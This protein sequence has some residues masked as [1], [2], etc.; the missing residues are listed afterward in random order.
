MLSPL[1]FRRLWRTSAAFAALAPGLAL[2]QTAPATAPAATAPPAATDA[3]A[4]DATDTATS[5]ATADTS[6]SDVASIV[7]TARRQAERAQDV[8]LAVTA[9]PSAVLTQTNAY[10]LADVQNLVPDLTAYQSN[11]RNS[12]LGIRGI[13][14]SSAADGLDTTVGVYVDGVYLGRPGMA[15]EDIV[16]VT[17]VEVL[18]GPQGTLYGRN[19]AAGVVNITTQAPSFTPRIDFEGSYGNYNFE[20]IKA[21]ITGPIVDDVLAARLTVFDTHRDGVLPNTFNGLSDNSIGRYGARLQFLYTPTPKLS[22]RVIAEYSAENDTCC[23]SVL[24]STLPTTFSKSTEAT[25]EAFSALGYNPVASTNFTQINAPQD[26]LTDQHSVSVEADYDLG[27]AKLTSI[28]A[29]RYW[30]FDPLQDSDG[31]P[32]DILQVNVAQTQDNQYTQEFRI[33]SNP[34]RLSWQAGV[35]LFSEDLYDHYILNQFGYQAGAFYTDYLHFDKGA[36]LTPGVSIAA[37]SQY[38]GVTQVGEDSEAVFAQANYKILDNLIL[39]AGVR[40]TNDWKHGITNTGV[41]GTPY[42][43]TSI[44]FQDNAG[45]A[46]NNVSYLGSL[47]YKVTPDVM[48]YISY[49]TGYQAAG[50]NLN[51]APAPGKSII[52]DPEDVTDLEGGVKSTF[53]HDRVLLNFD[54]FSEYLT[55]LQANI[56]P[57]TGKSYLANVGDIESEGVEVEGDWTVAKGLTLSAN[58]SYDHA[59]YTSYPDAP[60]PVGVLGAPSNQNLTGSQVYQAPKWVANV[61]A[62]YEWQLTDKVAPYA[63]IQYTYRSSVYGD[64]QESPGAVISGYSLVNARIGA[65]FGDRYDASLWVDNLANQVYFQNL[66]AASITGAGAY[67][68]SGA[69]GEP[70]TFGV[71][72]RAQF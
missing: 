10:D 60:P 51:A 40:Y 29:Y 2:A 28:S 33:A 44:L 27:W 35:F 4:T 52:L 25:F 32:L 63:Q 66:A 54:V 47:S 30:R 57:P 5:D 55:G 42:T 16:D 53:F 38:V 71:T 70:R 1:P 19:S 20:Q 67:G 64:V 3:A 12:S 48:A 41:N 9:L 34:G 43:A 15:L 23:V 45:V 7:V 50:L 39:T 68:F 46:G 56:S 65:H 8:P 24:K 61:L 31:T 6:A 22:I 36:P 18:N 14:V 37:G 49:S 62:R 26:M 21:S 69:L 13:G 11:A 72:L 58:G 59:Y 17:Q